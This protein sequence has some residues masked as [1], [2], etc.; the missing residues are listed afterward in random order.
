MKKIISA[1]LDIGSH[2]IK[3]M[4]LKKNKDRKTPEIIASESLTSRG[5]RRGEFIKK[6]ETTIVIK[7][8]LDRVNKK[9]GLYISHVYLSVS[10]TYLDSFET[11]Q[12]MS[13]MVQERMTDSI[14]HSIEEKMRKKIEREN[15]NK[16]VIHCEPTEYI[17]DGVKT[18][19]R[20]DG[21]FGSNV[22]VSFFVVT[23]FKQHLEN[24]KNAVEDA[25]LTI[26]GIIPAPIASAITLLQPVQKGGGCILADIGSQTLSLIIYENGKPI[27]IKVFPIGSLSI[28]M[29]IATNLE[30][31]PSEAEEIKLESSEQGEKVKQ[32]V[33][34]RVKK[35]F[36]II[37][38][39]LKSIGK[40]NADF[41][42]GII[43][44]GGGSGII[45]IEDISK[46]VLSLRTSIGESKVKDSSLSVVYG[47][48][49]YGI[50]ERNKWSLRTEAEK[51]L[52]KL[53][54]LVKKLLKPFKL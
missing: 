22:E 4:V 51:E 28:T 13:F 6:G 11:K 40:S 54:N 10:G 43:L 36:E 31:S 3:L 5:I 48:A 46:A 24:L 32:V 47:I 17:I 8:L 35:I 37:K 39:H 21:L 33:R 41:P 14:F 34:N 19:Q 27:S 26:K 1:G 42:F 50:E 16:E 15:I 38:E 7:K 12:S 2:K 45:S 44:S 49:A 30:I 9:Y 53:K 23:C 20:P 52:H 29:D 18:E 25:D